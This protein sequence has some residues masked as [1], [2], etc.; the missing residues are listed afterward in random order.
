[1]PRADQATIDLLT[2]YFQAM[3]VKDFDRLGGYY[4]QLYRMQYASSE[5]LAVN[6]EQLSRSNEQLP[7]DNQ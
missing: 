4:A 6:N 7:L 3:E 5:Q 1:M 2:D